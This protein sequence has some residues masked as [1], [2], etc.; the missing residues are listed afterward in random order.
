MSKVNYCPDCELYWYR[1]N[2]KEIEFRLYV[3]APINIEKCPFCIDPLKEVPKKLI[4]FRKK[5]I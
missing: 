4:K 1:I 5:A 2:D 3:F